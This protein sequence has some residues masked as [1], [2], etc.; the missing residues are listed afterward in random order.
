MYQSLELWNKWLSLT[1]ILKILSHPL[2][3][4]YI[5]Q[6]FMINGLFQKSDT[7]P[8]KIWESQ[9]TA[10]GI[11]TNLKQQKIITFWS[12]EERRVKSYFFGTK[13]ENSHILEFLFL[14]TKLKPRNSLFY[15]KIHLS[16]EGE[17]LIFGIA[18]YR[19]H[20]DM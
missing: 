2:N 5:S 16:S 10:I 6:L 13:N 18:H 3:I 9:L 4:N 14:K 12:Q 17:P 7:H 15:W 20:G 1:F 19:G 11:K 8:L